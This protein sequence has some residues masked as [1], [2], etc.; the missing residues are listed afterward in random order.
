MQRQPR[1]ICTWD[2]GFEVYLAKQ[3]IAL[4]VSA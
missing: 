1:D 4:V 3:V 2:P